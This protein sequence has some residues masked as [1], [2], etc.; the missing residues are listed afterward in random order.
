MHPIQERIQAMTRRHFFGGA[1]LGLGTAALASLL[2]DRGV[3]DEATVETGGLPSLPHFAPKAK[4][5]IYLFMAGA[6]CQ[7]DLLDYK[8]LLNERH[9][10]TAPAECYADRSAFVGP[11][12]KVLGSPYAFEQVGSSGAWVSSMSKAAKAPT[13]TQNITRPKPIIPIVLSNSLP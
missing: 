10:E 12:E 9:G 11:N 8:P 5:A 13:K 1:S 6:P 7:M 2:P 4:R 3:A